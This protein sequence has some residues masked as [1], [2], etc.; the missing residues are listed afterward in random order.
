MIVAE[1]VAF[2]V[3]FP[4]M[5]DSILDVSELDRASRSTLGF[6]F[7]TTPQEG[8][9]HRAPV[10]SPDGEPSEGDDPVP[11]EIPPRDPTPHQEPIPHQ[12]PSVER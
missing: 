7:D 12:N 10:P 11:T 3:R 2:R 8:I 9:M 1:G 6:E 5:N 4:K